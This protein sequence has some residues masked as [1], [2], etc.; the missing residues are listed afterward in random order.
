MVVRA[1][2]IVRSPPR[3]SR[4]VVSIQV[5]NRFTPAITAR[6]ASAANLNTHGRPVVHP[7]Q[8]QPEPR[9]LDDHQNGCRERL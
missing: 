8:G 4:V 9:A 2:P 6:K 1:F 7:V 5:T 3:I